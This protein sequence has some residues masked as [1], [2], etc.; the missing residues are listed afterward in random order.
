MAISVSVSCLSLS[1]LLTAGA[2]CFY[3]ARNAKVSTAENIQYLKSHIITM[4][5]CVPAGQDGVE[6]TNSPVSYFKSGRHSH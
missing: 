1:L 3:E 6:Q 2:D 4:S 5:V